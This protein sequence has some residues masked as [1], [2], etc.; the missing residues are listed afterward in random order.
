MCEHEKLFNFGVWRL[1]VVTVA[2]LGSNSSSNVGIYLIPNQFS[3]E[4]L[5]L[6]AVRY[7]LYN[8]MERA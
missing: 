7:F 3:N 1:V 6:K 4:I 5:C 2:K 8:I